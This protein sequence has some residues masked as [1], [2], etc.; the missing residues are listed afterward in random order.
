[1]IIAE[2]QIP[3]YIPVKQ[4]KFDGSIIDW[5]FGP[6]F[7]CLYAEIWY[8]QVSITFPGLLQGHYQDFLRTL[9]GLS[10]DFLRT[11]SGLDGICP[12]Y[13]WSGPKYDW[14]CLKY[15]CIFFSPNYDFFLDLSKTRRGSPVDDRP[16]TDKIDHFVQ[17]KNK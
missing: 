10:Q 15:K 17:K 3:P 13:K 12:K 6:L 8:V 5:L 4:K 14:I 16:Y 2:P 11:F 9:S 7:G 1:M